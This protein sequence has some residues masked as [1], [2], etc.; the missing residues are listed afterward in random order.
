MSVM[1]QIES[2]VRG[3]EKG[4][5]EGI[6]PSYL[7]GFPIFLRNFATSLSPNLS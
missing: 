3:K 2:D 1:V 6:V 4:E 7:G 5:R